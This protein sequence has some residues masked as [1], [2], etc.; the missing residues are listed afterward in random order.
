M[1]VVDPSVFLRL[2]S[3]SEK[4]YFEK[5]IP[6]VDGYII[7]ANLVE[8]TPLACASLVFRFSG[9]KK[10]TPYLLD[11]MT[12]V[13]GAYLDPSINVVRHDLD[14][15]KSDQ[16]RKKKP[17]RDF[18][19]SYKGLGEVFG[20]PFAEAMCDNENQNAAI[21][22]S[23]LSSDE[24]ITQV[25]KTVMDYQ[26]QRIPNIFRDV[27]EDDPVAAELT[28]GFPLPLAII[29]PYFYIE[30]SEEASWI[31]I[32]L[33]MM[34]ET[35]S[36][37]PDLPV[38]G[39]LCLD[40]S[41]LLEREKIDK[42]AQNILQTGIKGIWLWI[43]KLNEDELTGDKEINVESTDKCM[44]LSAVRY[45]VETLSN[46]IEVY[47]MHGG[48]FSLVLSKF[49]MKGISHGVGYGEQKDVVPVIGQAIPIV[50]YYLP[51]IHRR[52]GVPDIERC[53]HSLGIR[54]PNDFYEQ[55]CDCAICRGVVNSS[56]RQFR[57]FGEMKPPKSG[58]QRSTQTPD[59]ARRCRFHFLL[60]RIRERDWVKKVTLQQI[61]DSL[62]SSNQKWGNQPTVQRYCPHLKAWGAVLANED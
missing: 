49:G 23:D 51:N 24:V 27:I 30:P 37:D 21:S 62:N 33:R 31:D 17:V 60:T 3:H 57:L 34:K 22:P 44:K 11:P 54:E 42:I 15:I 36:L 26:L 18:K 55:I 50:R 46:Q 59:A 32:N 40:H 43:S 14:W 20:G 56:V 8:S 38:H 39:V 48:F 61:V 53:F 35:V 5:V 4:D 25:S 41:I 45:L 16:K 28:E 1:P 19:R 10:N 29:A 12:Y 2:G 47:N 7:A 52:L 58:K 6:F 13:F 9:K